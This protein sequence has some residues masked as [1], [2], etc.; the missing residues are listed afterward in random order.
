MNTDIN[1]AANAIADREIN[2][3]NTS[4]PNASDSVSNLTNNITQTRRARHTLVVNEETLFEDCFAYYKSPDFDPN[5]P[6]RIRFENQ[7]AIDAGG[8]CRHFFTLIS[9]EIIDKLFEGNPGNM[10]PKIS[11]NTILC[12]IYVAVGK[13]IAHSIVHGCQGLPFLSSAAYNYICNGSIS[14]AASFVTLEQVA[15]GVYAHYIKQV[16]FSSH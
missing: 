11:A 6:I 4:V 5:I 16:C 3:N 9:H 7:I 12:E 10:L 2:D 13:V 14:E 1:E 15:S 8:L